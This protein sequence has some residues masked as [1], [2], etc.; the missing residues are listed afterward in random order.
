MFCPNLK[1][2]IYN[3]GVVSSLQ[4]SNKVDLFTIYIFFLDFLGFFVDFLDFPVFFSV[5]LGFSY[6]FL[7]FLRFCLV[8]L[9]FSLFCLLFLGFFLVSGQFHLAR[10]ANRRF[11]DDFAWPGLQIGGFRPRFGDLACKNEEIVVISLKIQLF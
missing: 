10:A 1:N 6:F 11:F 2:E 3:F 5:F 8:F 7:V 9:S 4:I